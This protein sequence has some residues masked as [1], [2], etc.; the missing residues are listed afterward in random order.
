MSGD[1]KMDDRPEKY[2]QQDPA[3]SVKNNMTCL[4]KLLAVDHVARGLHADQ[5]RHPL[6]SKDL[7]QQGRSTMPANRS[8]F[9]SDSQQ[10]GG[11]GV[12]NKRKTA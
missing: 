4:L 6:F 1:G 5:C 8:T 7:L 3:A 9:P 2:R 11:A 10:G 12:E